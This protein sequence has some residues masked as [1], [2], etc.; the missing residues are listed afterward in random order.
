[1][2]EQA[3]NAAMNMT[4]MLGAF[5]NTVAEEIGREQALASLSKSLENLGAMSGRM[6]KEQMGIEKLDVSTVGSIMKGMGE[7]YGLTS[8]V[9][10]GPKTVLVKNYN[11][12]FYDGLRAAGFDHEAIEAFCRHGPATMVESFLGQ[13]DPTVKYQLRKFRSS[14]EDFCEEETVL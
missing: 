1:V 2:S 10:E 12:P 5:F 3:Y 14:A 4:G 11:C 6:M 9:K 7:T 8:Q 13:I